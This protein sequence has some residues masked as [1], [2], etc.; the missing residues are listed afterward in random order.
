MPLSLFSMSCFEIDLRFMHVM[1]VHHVSSSATYRNQVT[2]RGRPRDSE[3]HHQGEVPCYLIESRLGDWKRAA[4]IRWEAMQRITG[5]SVEERCIGGYGF[6]CACGGYDDGGRAMDVVMKEL[7]VITKEVMIATEEEV[8]V[9]ETVEE[10]VAVVVTAVTSVTRVAIVFTKQVVVVVPEKDHKRNLQAQ[11]EPLGGGSF[12]SVFWRDRGLYTHDR[13]SNDLVNHI[14][15]VLRYFIVDVVDPGSTPNVV[16]CGRELSEKFLKHRHIDSWTTRL[17]E[18]R[19]M[20]KLPSETE[21]TRKVKEIFG[22]QEKKKNCW[23]FFA[24]AAQVYRGRIHESVESAASIRKRGFRA[25]FD[26]QSQGVCDSHKVFSEGF[27][28]VLGLNLHG[29]SVA[30]GVLIYVGISARWYSLV[31][32]K[33]V[34]EGLKKIGSCGFVYV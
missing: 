21:E 13:E 16:C 29:I 23:T 25:V 10:Q 19:H 32:V 8:V 31:S 6:N 14:G 24:A 17:E 12:H 20:K 11:A 26:L 22:L 33:G 3:I 2:P 27:H 15:G 5:R 4:T 28:G 7:M 18:E 34:E 9:E 1:F 30:G